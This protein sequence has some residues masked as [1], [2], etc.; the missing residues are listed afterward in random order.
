M[1]PG[2]SSCIAVPESQKVP[3]TCRGINESFWVITATTQKGNLSQDISLAAQSHA[4]VI[5]LMGLR[6]LDEIIAVFK[7]EH[8]GHLPIMIMQNG[9][10]KSERCVIGDIN[11]I[12]EKVVRT[13]L[14]TPAM[15]VIGAVVR[16]H[17]NY[18]KEMVLQYEGASIV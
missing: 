13:K 12:K 2:I 18:A 9:S 14:G 17:P 3:L 7:K 10:R 11:S 4:T 15:M 6:K 16:L 1:I 8:K 5:V